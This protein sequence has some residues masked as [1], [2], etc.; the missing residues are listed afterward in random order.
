MVGTWESRQEPAGIPFILKNVRICFTTSSSSLGNNASLQNKPFCKN[1]GKCNQTCEPTNEIF[2]SA[3]MG[4][5]LHVADSIYLPWNESDNECSLS[6]SSL[7]LSMPC[8]GGKPN[9]RHFFAEEVI[10]RLFCSK[11]LC[12][13]CCLLSACRLE[14]MICQ[15]SSIGFDFDGQVWPHSRFWVQCSFPSYRFSPVSW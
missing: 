6:L 11:I 4:Q 2:S 9:G 5:D 7:E 12:L 3:L 15:L 8:W 14:F 13:H 1:R 10:K